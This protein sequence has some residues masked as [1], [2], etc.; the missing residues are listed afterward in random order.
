MRTIDPVLHMR[1]L[2]EERMDLIAVADECMDRMQERLAAAL[3]AARKAERRCVAMED[4][5][6][7][8]MDRIKLL[9]KENKVLRASQTDPPSSSLGG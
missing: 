4:E 5:R 8:F 2:L 3:R 7:M 1:R 6:R 9:Q